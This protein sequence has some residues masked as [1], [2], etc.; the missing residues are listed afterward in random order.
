M[1]SSRICAYCSSHHVRR[2]GHFY[3]RH[4][5]RYLKR[6]RCQQCLKTFSGRTFSSHKNQKKPH[7][8]QLI[9]L[10]LTSGVTQRRCAKKLN[11]SRST[12]HRKLVFLSG[13]ARKI[14]NQQKFQASEVQFDE[15]ETIEHT[16]LKPLTIGLCVTNDYKIVGVKVG[17]LAA[18]GRLSRLSKIKYGLRPTHREEVITEILKSAANLCPNLRLIKSDKHPIYKPLVTKFLPHVSYEQYESRGHKEK[19]RERLFHKHIK[20]KFDPLFA[21]NQRCAS[22]RADIRRLTRRS[23]CTTKLPHYLEEHL[24]LFIAQNNGYKIA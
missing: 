9:L 15:M 16:K 14:H 3:V 18:K 24:Y 2:H 1:Q 11:C 23:W 20:S 21:L 19:Y 6:Y 7:L 8:N 5:R 10:D 17:S 12:V 22:L 13:R 4:T